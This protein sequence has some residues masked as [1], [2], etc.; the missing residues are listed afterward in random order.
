MVDETGII[1]DGWSKK[2]PLR[3]LV[4]KAESYLRTRGVKDADDKKKEEKKRKKKL[5]YLKRTHNVSQI[6][7]AS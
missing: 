4:D 7:R 3:Q 2:F 1:P 5:P 6:G